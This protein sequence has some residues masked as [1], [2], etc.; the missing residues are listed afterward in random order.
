M[1]ALSIRQPWAW[2][3]VQ[4]HKDVEN[5]CWPTTFRGRILV[6]AGAHLT[7]PDYQACVLFI[8]GIGPRDWRLPAYDVLKAQCGGIVGEVTIVDCVTESASPWF[9]GEYGFVLK[10]AKAT[11]FW[12]FKGALSF[13]QVPDDRLEFVSKNLL[14]D[15]PLATRNK[16]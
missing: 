8:A 6:H 1:K 2:L 14:G 3:I 15:Y 16:V 13:F 7:K 5:R 4:G 10:L 12:P 11:E 9:T